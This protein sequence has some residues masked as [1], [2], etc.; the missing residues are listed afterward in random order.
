MTQ[1]QRSVLALFFLLLVLPARGSGQPLSQHL[2]ILTPLVGKT[3]VGRMTSPDG[4]QAFTVERTFQPQWD[5]SVVRFSTSAEIGSPSEGFYYWDRDAKQVAVFLVNAR[6]VYQRGTVSAAGGI[7][8][9][10]GRISFPD[11]A[12]DY[13]NTFEL[14]PDG[15]LVDRWF[16]NAF[17]DWRPGHV[18]ELRPRQIPGP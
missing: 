2:S 9:V 15:T 16:Q 12:F 8:T 10:E 3:W 14:R 1:I 7:I 4:R 13:R 11:R 5:G 6:G 18:V 17:G